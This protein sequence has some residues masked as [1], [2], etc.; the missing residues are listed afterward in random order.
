MIKQSACQ[1]RRCK[2]YGF[3]P[4]V[5]KISLEKDKATHCSILAWR[6]PWIAEPDGLQS[7]GLQR[8]RHE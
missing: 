5:G 1:C 3:G 4:W 8:I 6:I 7:V 2:R